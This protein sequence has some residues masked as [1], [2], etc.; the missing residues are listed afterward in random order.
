MKDQMILSGLLHNEDYMRKVIPFLKDEYFDDNTTKLLFNEYCDFVKKYN[1][2][3]TKQSLFL[4]IEE[5]SNI[6]EDQFKE[7]GVALDNTEYDPLTNLDWLVNETEK[8]CQ[9]KAIF[10][11]LRRSI[12]II[13]GQ[14][15]E[16]DKGAIPQILQDALGVCFDSRVGH[17]LTEDAEQRYESYHSVEDRVPFDIDILNT[18]TKGG[19]PRGTLS[20]F[21]A[22]CVHPNTKVRI[23]YRG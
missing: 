11:A 8:F 5:K 2:L 6:N 3:P 19:F 1:T 15:K 12:G 22:G 23:R 20:V 4:A 21:L 18:I 7:V 14:V 10:N 13:D 9:E 16:L 17:N